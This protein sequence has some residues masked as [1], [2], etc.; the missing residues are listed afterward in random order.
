M[1]QVAKLENM[2]KGWFVGNFEPTLLKT[3]DVEIAVKTYK[4][5]DSEEKHYHKIATEITVITSGR[6][7][8]NDVEYTA[9]DIIVIEP[10]EVTDFECLEDS[11]TAVVKYP[12]ANDDK[13]VGDVEQ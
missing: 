7:R 3:N 12:G 1:M 13:Y 8:M 5:G 11:I 2:V 4:K 9:G 10:N 6:V